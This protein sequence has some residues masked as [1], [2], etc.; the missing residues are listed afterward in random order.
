MEIKRKTVIERAKA[1]VSNF[2]Q[3]YC[4]L[5]QKV[6]LGGLSSSTLN[7]YGRCIAQIGLHFKQD[8]TAFE[9]EQIN[10][11]LYDLKRG[12]NPSNSYFKHAVYG[13]RYIFRI[14]YLADKAIKLPGLCKSKPDNPMHRH[15]KL[16]DFIVSKARKARKLPIYITDLPILLQ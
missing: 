16:A 14:H 9:E 10:G 12:K 15:E 4:A 8:P 6:I 1:E 11:Y 5:E 2:A 13:L 3:M 7:N